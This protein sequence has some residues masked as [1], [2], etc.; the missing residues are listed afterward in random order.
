MTS[1]EQKLVVA[2]FQRKYSLTVDGVFG[3]A[4]EA[5]ANALLNDVTWPLAKLP[6]GRLAQVTS[7]FKTNNPSRP[8]HNGVDLFYR[9]QD[10]DP[11]VAKNRQVSHEGTRRWWIPEGTHAVAFAD[12]TVLD[13]RPSWATGGLVWVQ[14]DNRP[15]LRFGFMHLEKTLVLKGEKVKKGDP[16]GLVGHNP[17][18][19]SNLVHLHFEISPVTKYSPVDP[20][21]HLGSNH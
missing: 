6:D 20:E 19:A 15:W 8:N 5:R 9:Y 18:D 3:P 17:Q 7:G 11:A 21:A 4:T 16:I 1:D 2:E 13:V 12:G 14:W 10:T